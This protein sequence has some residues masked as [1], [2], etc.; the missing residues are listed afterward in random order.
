MFSLLMAVFKAFT[1]LV[2]FLDEVSNRNPGSSAEDRGKITSLKRYVRGTFI[3]LIMFGIFCFTVFKVVVPLHTKNA[4]LEQEL[5]SRDIAL[6][7]R[8]DK[9]EKLDKANTTLQGTSNT[10][11]SLLYTRDE[12]IKRLA[13]DLAECRKSEVAYREFL[14]N[15]ESKYAPIATP[16][17]KKPVNPTKET[18]PKS[19]PTVTEVEP[20]VVENKS[21]KISDTA[22]DKLKTLKE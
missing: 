7:E 16:K 12:D 13:S 20:K 10:Q 19:P 15:L 9:I 11:S 18:K 17:A 4:I 21:T 5:H 3:R 22:K 8:M 14:L 6:K 2:P 1:Q